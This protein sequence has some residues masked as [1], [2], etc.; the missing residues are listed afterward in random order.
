VC[1]KRRASVRVLTVVKI[2]ASDEAGRSFLQKHNYKWSHVLLS[3]IWVDLQ[4]P[5]AEQKR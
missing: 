2:I 4:T 1:G 3:E 5:T